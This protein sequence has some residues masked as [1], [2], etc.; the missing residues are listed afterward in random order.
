MSPD[1]APNDPIQESSL[2]AEAYFD[3]VEQ[4]L[5]A[6][7]QGDLIIVADDADRENEGD[8]IGIAEHMTPESVNFMAQ[9]GRGLICLAMSPELCDQLDLPDMVQKNTEAMQTAFTIS[10]D[11]HPKYGVTTGISSSDRAKTIQVAVAPDTVPADLRRP[12]HIFPLR[13]KPG[14][15]LQRVGHTEAAV[16][17]A[18]LAGAR[19]AGVI[20][21]ILNPDGTMARRNELFKFAKKHRLKFITVA[22]LIAYRLDKEQMLELETEAKLPTRFGEF[23]VKAFRNRLDNSEHLAIT[24]G[25]LAAKDATPLIRVHS[26]CLTGDLLAS[27]RCDCGFQLHTALEKIAET[28][29]GALIYLR[30]HEGRGIGLMN[31]LR[32]YELQDQ[33]MDTVDANLK[34]GFP[35]DLRQYGIGAQIIV[36]LGV[37][38]FNLLTNNPRKIRGLD[39]Y[40]LEIVERVPLITEPTQA[41][42]HY[43]KTKEA[44]LGHLLHD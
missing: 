42:E 34:L 5:E 2:P 11:A 37:T 25:E 9:E 28:G 21:E 43:L 18:K 24:M 14:G 8:L 6:L 13:A 29:C 33:G 12:G 40:G 35:P 30:Q 23:T 44:R 16:D 19:P 3:S 7:R 15:V 41:N 22:Q 26:E 20:C 31:K 32:A 17:L 38:R 36:E 4:A 39:G 10:I 1:N 27:L